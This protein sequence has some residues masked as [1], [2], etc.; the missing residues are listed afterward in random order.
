[1]ER[2][3]NN[4]FHTSRKSKRPENISLDPNILQ[5]IIYPP[6][7]RQNLKK[8]RKIIWKI[9]KIEARN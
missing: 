7:S 4:D 8:I 3:L 9:Y 5:P 6:N 2:D 1:M